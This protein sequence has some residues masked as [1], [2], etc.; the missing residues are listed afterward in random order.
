[1]LDTRF[2][3][4]NEDFDFCTRARRK[5]FRVVH[6]TDSKIWHKVSI[7]RNKLMNNM[8]E[9][10]ALLGDT[11]DFRFKDRLLFFKICSPWKIQ[12]ISQNIFYF[13]YVLPLSALLTCKR[14]GVKVTFTQIKLI[15]K[16]VFGI[17]K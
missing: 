9:R 2:P 5:N 11:G 13:A 7:S 12:R 17:F 14:S 16:E 4:G 1:M 8:A 3:F 15:L 10:K 6:V